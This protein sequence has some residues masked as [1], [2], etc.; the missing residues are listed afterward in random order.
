MRRRLVCAL[1]LCVVSAS[2]FG[3][4]KPE[5]TAEKT[6][7][8]LVMPDA[9]PEFF[10]AEANPVHPGFEREILEGYVRARKMHLTVI[11][12]ENWDDLMAQLRDGRGD[13]IA[14]HF[15]DT[16]E[17]RKT[18]DFTHGI[19]PTQTVLITRK[20]GPRITTQEEL[21]KRKIGAVKGGASLK[22]VV[23]AGA[24]K[25]NIDESATQDKMVELLQSGRVSALARALPLAILNQR[26]DPELELGMF[27]GA[28]THFAWGVRK[29]DTKLR[30]A[31]N[32]HLGIVRRTGAWQ[33]FVVKYFGEAAVDMIKQA[34]TR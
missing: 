31:L 17:R 5:P 14:G 29:E 15:T 23:A 13:I 18:I 1:G 22:A 33:R 25:L 19:M 27:V 20:P 24:P 4:A 30:D 9:R 7:R 8:V 3:A 12:A 21:L 10:A 34:E 6:F 2:A 11:R 16:E 28:R 26:E 32:E